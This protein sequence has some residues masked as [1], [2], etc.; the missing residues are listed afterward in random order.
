[1]LEIAFFLSFVINENGK[2][3]EHIHF[4]YWG[5]VIFTLRQIYKVEVAK[6]AW[7]LVQV[8]KCAGYQ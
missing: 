6:S 4:S 8:G 5:L 7:H 1:M 2:H 3:I